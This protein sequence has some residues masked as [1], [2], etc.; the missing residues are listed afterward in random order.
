MS[1]NPFYTSKTKHKSDTIVDSK[2]HWENIYKT[3][4]PTQVSW[5]QEHLQTPL[6]LIEQTGVEKTAQIIDVGGGAS[7]LVDDLLELGGGFRPLA[8]LIRH[9]PR[10][11][12]GVGVA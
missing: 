7:T 3:K 12:E 1:S 8:P 6:R 11:I 10:A 4:A 9:P 5:Y 2:S